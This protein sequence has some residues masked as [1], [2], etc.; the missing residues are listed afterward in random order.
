[1]TIK[2]SKKLLSPEAILKIGWILFKNLA[3]SKSNGVEKKIK[4]PRKVQAPGVNYGTC[5]A[6]NGTGQVLKITNTILGRMQTSTTC[7]VCSGSGKSI[8]NKPLGS[9]QHGMI[10]K[11]ETVTAGTR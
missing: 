7:D 10:K 5:S 6:C 11:E 4:V 2:S 3:L 8:L 1:M 9:D